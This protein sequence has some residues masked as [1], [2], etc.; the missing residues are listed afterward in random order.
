MPHYEWVRPNRYVYEGGTVQGD[1]GAYVEQ[2]C[3]EICHVDDGVCEV[4]P[5]GNEY[6]GNVKCPDTRPMPCPC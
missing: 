2:Y 1:L 4:I 5:G 3:H 6:T